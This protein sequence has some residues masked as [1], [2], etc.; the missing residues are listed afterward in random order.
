MAILEEFFT[1]IANSIRTSSRTTANIPANNFSAEILKLT[2]IK[3]AN[4]TAADIVTGK[5]AYINSGKVTGTGPNIK[6]ATATAADIITGKTAYIG[7]GKVTGTGPN[8]QDATA[9]AA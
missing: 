9:T 5:T 7:S 4:A 6:D 2:N 3:D 1:N 8:T